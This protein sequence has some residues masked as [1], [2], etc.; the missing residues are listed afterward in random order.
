MPKRLFPIAALALSVRFEAPPVEGEFV[1]RQKRFLA[2]VRVEGRVELAF[3]P[4]TARMA[5]L[6]APENPVLLMDRG[7]PDRSTRW[8]LVAVE[9][10]HTLVTIDSRVPNRVVA[11]ALARGDL[12]ELRAYDSVRPERTWGSSR[13]DFHLSGNGGEAL[14]EVKGCTLVDA[15]GRALFPDAPTARGARH[16]RELAEGVASGVRGVLIVVV[17]RGDGRVFSPNDRTD[18][19]FGDALREASAS[20][21]EVI[22]R[23]ARVDREGVELGTT[24]AVDLEGLLQEVDGA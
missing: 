16:V 18:R 10:P 11:E 5:E 2:M 23:R 8:D 6:L 7:H 19:A 22:A 24:V 15:D 20:G 12:P 13:F 9:L 21:V 17:Q 3:V 14:V 4:N 1:H